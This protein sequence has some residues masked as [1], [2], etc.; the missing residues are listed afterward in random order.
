MSSKAVGCLHFMELIY[1]IHFEFISKT[2]T[3]D[4]QTCSARGCGMATLKE[5]EPAPPKRMPYLIQP[6]QIFAGE[7]FQVD[8]QRAV[9][10]FRKAVLDN[11]SHDTLTQYTLDTSCTKYMK[12]RPPREVTLIC[13]GGKRISWTTRSLLD[14]YSESDRQNKKEVWG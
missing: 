1:V 11:D 14:F 6:W 4:T 9:S 13:R 8:R 7:Q 12:G 5:K 10:I 3:D 2:M